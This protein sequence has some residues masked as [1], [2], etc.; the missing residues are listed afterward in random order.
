MDSASMDRLIAAHIDAETAGD[1]QAAISMY[2][3]DV[4]HDVVGF[5][6]GPVQ[7]KPTEIV[8]RSMDVF[9]NR[10][11]KWLCVGSQST[12]RTAKEAFPTLGETRHAPVLGRRQR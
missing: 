8:S 11:G 12:R 5:P 7:G 3:E 6:T 2:T 1:P 4:E 10:D 9:V